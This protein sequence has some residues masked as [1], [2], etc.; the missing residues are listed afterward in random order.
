MG[1][2]IHPTGFR[3]GVNKS[4][5]STW[6]SN[7]CTYSQVLKE[8]YQIRNFFEKECSS[9][10]N[11]AGISKLEIKRKVNQVELLIHAARPKAIASGSDEELAFTNLRNKLKKLITNSKQIRIKVIQVNKMETESTLIA[12]A[13]AEQLEKRVDFKKAMRQSAQRLQKNGTKGF[14]LQISGRLNGAEMARDEWLR[15][16]RVPLQ[17][18]RADISYATARAYTTYGV[19]GVKV[20]I[21]NKEII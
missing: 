10:Y 1:Q 14:K 6:F 2:K 3:I 7:Y 8:D 18:L 13:L 17:T 21:F 4:H 15:E 16:G 9:L 11:K 12:R 19:L 5:D 20:W